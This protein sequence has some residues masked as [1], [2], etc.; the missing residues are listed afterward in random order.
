MSTKLE[1][2]RAHLLDMAK[3]GVKDAAAA[4]RLNKRREGTYSHGVRAMI[5]ANGDAKAFVKVC[6]DLMAAI[7]VNADGIAK[8]VGAKLAKRTSDDG[9]KQYRV[10]GALSSVK[11]YGKQ[12]LEWGIA[13][14]DEE[15]GETPRPYGQIRKDVDSERAKRELADEKPEDTQ[16]REIAETC[17]LIANRAKSLDG[18]GLDTLHSIV[19]QVWESLNGKTS[20]GEK[21]EDAATAEPAEDAPAKATRKRATR[22]RKAKAA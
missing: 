9:A 21:L 14:V 16:R 5:A 2:I 7:R 4:E 15:D 12:A 17:E 3:G 1:L 18:E 22:T 8:E 10:P 13:L 11:T 20:A 6:E 19:S